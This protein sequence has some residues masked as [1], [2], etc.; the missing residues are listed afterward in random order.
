MSGPFRNPHAWSNLSAMIRALPLFLLLAACSD[1]PEVGRA[2]A[3]LADPGDTPPL[4]T[5]DAVAMIGT[6]VPD[7]PSTLATEAA[8]LRARAL[9]LRQR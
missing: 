6:A 5:A 3:A 1:F 9:V 7:Q 2:E 4:L 8:A